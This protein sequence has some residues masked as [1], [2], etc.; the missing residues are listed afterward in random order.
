LRTPWP[1]GSFSRTGRSA[2]FFALNSAKPDGIPAPFGLSAFGASA[3]G[4]RGARSRLLRARAARWLAV[5]LAPYGGRSGRVQLANGVLAHVL[6]PLGPE[7]PA[8]P[9]LR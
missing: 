4:G 3:A 5:H 9:C 6:P 8:Q 1:P 7:R 2:S